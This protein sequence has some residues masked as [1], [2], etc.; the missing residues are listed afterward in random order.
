MEKVEKNV[1]ID[2]VF[3]KVKVKP[4]YRRFR[5]VALRDIT[6]GKPVVRTYRISWNIV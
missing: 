6:P 5:A 2:A 4:M 3:G 1:L